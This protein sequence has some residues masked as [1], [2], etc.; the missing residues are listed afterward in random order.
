MISSLSNPKVKKVRRLQADKRYRSSQKQFIVEGTRWAA[1]LINEPWLQD[2]FFTEKWRN[3]ADHGEWLAKMPVQKHLVTEEVM[4]SMSSTETPPGILA[5]AAI[6]PLPIPQ[7]LSLVLILDSITN[8]GNLGTMLRTAAAAGVDAVFLAPGCVD[9]YNPKVV[10]GSMG[11]L[12]RLPILELAWRE[13]GKVV[14]D[15]QIWAA[16][17]DGSQF[18]TAVNWRRPAALIIGNEAHGISENA[19]NLAQEAI[20]V[21]MSRGT[22]SLNA[23]IAAGIILFEA[24]RQ[25]NLAEDEIRHLSTTS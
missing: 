19:A 14:G 5:L 16:A 25:R 2:V 11:A 24:V 3:Q 15:M 17:A 20:S 13:I 23:A 10:R 7:H 4:T 22:E 18:Y 6:N 12:L 8:P 1:E 21:P 9:I